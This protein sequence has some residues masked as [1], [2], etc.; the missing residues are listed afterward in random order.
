[1]VASV[2]IARTWDIA[3]FSPRVHVRMSQMVP[4]LTLD[5]RFEDCHHGIQS[6]GKPSKVVKFPTPMAQIFVGGASNSHLAPMQRG[7]F[8]APCWSRGRVPPEAFP[9]CLPA[10]EGHA[11]APRKYTAFPLIGNV[12]YLCRGNFGRQVPQF[13][14]TSDT[15][16][17]VFSR[18]SRPSSPSV[19]QPKPRRGRSSA[20]SSPRTI[21]WA[22]RVSRRSASIVGSSNAI[23]SMCVT[24]V[25]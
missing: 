25:P 24:E 16:S 19:T 21:S 5:R 6:A 14:L 18:C 7:D 22:A 12:G 23:V 4:F 17:L 13:F 2:F 11:S 10:A 9:D 8:N 1:M 3:Q 15:A 20:H